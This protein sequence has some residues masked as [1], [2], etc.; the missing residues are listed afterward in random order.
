[1]PE[2][3]CSTVKNVH[4]FILQFILEVSLEL[5]KYTWATRKMKFAQIFTL[6]I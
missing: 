1:M 5:F 6:D 3:H 2:F 4:T